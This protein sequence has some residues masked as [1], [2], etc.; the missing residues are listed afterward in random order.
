MNNKMNKNNNKKIIAFSGGGTGGSVSPLLALKQSLAKDNPSWGFVWFGTKKGLEKEMLKND[1]SRYIG[2]ASG[3]FR[4]YFSFKNF[5]DIFKI[6]YAFF[7]SIFWLLKTK[8]DLVMSAGSFVSV[9][10]AWAA[11][12]CKIPV[13]VHQQ[14]VRP[15]LANKLMAKV[16]TKVSVTFFKSLDD[17]GKKAVLT[18]N[19]VRKE[20]FELRNELDIKKD[21]NLDLDRKIITIV[22]G[23]QGA[24]YI[25]NLIKESLKNL[26]GKYQIIHITGKGNN[27][28][29]KI[30][31]Y[32]PF[33]FVSGKKMSEILSVSDLV[34]SRCGLGF[35]TELSFLKKPCI[36]IPIINSHQEDNADIISNNFAGIVLSQDKTNKDIFVK[37]VNDILNNSDK[38]YNLANNLYNIMPKKALDNLK[39]L[40]KE[41]VK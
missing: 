10:L 25:N 29:Q 9:P 35:I 22:G 15:G 36:F 41:N 7:E 13:I 17:Y 1:S 30:S 6:I 2:I 19:P 21:L 4:R 8:P 32:Y 37:E 31:N 24:K 40:V 16:S 34:V 20:F 39:N 14:D 23:G 27:N 18:G 12:F 26:A 11:S 3:K 38:A 28:L 33:E 5:F